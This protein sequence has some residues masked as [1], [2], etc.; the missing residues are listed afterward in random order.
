MKQ[1]PLPASAQRKADIDVP[2]LIVGGGGAGLTASMLLSQLGIE[3]LLVSALPTTSILPKAHVLNQ[4]TMEILADVGVAEAIY[5]KSTPAENMAAMGWYCGF[6]GPDEDCGRMI[7]RIES[8]GAGYTNLNW[9]A[10][11][12]LR[13]ANLPQIRLE[14]ILKA[15]AE[16]MAPGTVRFH[17]ELVAVE[18]DAD[19]VV[20]RSRT[21][22]ARLRRWPHDPQAAW[23]GIRGP[24]RGRADRHRAHQRGSLA[25]RTRPRRAHPMD[26]V[27]G[28]RRDGGAGADGA[29]PLGSRQRRM[30]VPRHLPG[31]G[32]QRPHRRADRGQH[33]SRPGHRRADEGPQDH[34]LGS[35]G[36]A[37]AEVSGRPRVSRRRLRAPPPT[38]RRP[39]TDQRR[40]GRAQPVLEA[41]RGAGRLRSRQPAGK[42]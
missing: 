36:R 5:E 26:L 8:W 9:M 13:T 20:H 22:S 7:G 35:G 10:A 30:G 19:G 3:T 40:A 39:G 25:A 27:P 15:H 6:A 38:H 1:Q 24:G 12:P 17:H 16:A 18:Q 2:V 41:C 32:A 29:R 11:S 14:P 31:R 21:V 34:P 28:D 4:R 33:A 37:R 23:R 42:L